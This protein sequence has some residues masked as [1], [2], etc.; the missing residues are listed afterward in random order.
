M[1][2]SSS[3]TIINPSIV[4]RLAKLYQRKIE[5]MSSLNATDEEVQEVL[6]D[7]RVT[8]APPPSPPSKKD[9]TT[10]FK[11]DVSGAN[12][13]GETV[14]EMTHQHF[15]RGEDDERFERK[16][17]KREFLSLD[18]ETENVQVQNKSQSAVP[19]E[20]EQGT[21]KVGS[22]FNLIDLLD[23][24]QS[25]EDEGTTQPCHT[26]LTNLNQI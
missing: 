15:I 3:S 16:S 24:E 23:A 1:K 19:Y 9:A 4:S 25:D 2:A 8:L 12:N 21:T 17:D 5:L 18:D 10:K 20:E 13:T 6:E 26:H 7:M 22:G 14:K 11:A